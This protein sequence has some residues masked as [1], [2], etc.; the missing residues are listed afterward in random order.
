[1]RNPRPDTASWGKSLAG[2]SARRAA[3]DEERRKLEVA[4]RA[5]RLEDAKLARQIDRLGGG[6][7]ARATRTATVTVGC[8]GLGQVTALVSYVVPGAGWQPEYDLDF[9]PRARARVGAGTARLT[10]GAVVRQT[11]GEDWRGVRLALSTARPKLGAEA[12]R[13]APLVVDGS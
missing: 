10:V 11:T 7:G 12:P 4:L 3:Q 6:G 13:P 8:R 5:L 1:M 2:L 9:A